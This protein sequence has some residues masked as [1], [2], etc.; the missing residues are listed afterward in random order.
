[1][2]TLLLKR[3]SFNLICTQGE[4]WLDGQFSCFTLEPP[5]ESAPIKPR[6]IPLGIYAFAIA[7]P[8]EKHACYHPLLKEIPDFGA[9]EIYMG[10][11]PSDTK[12]RILV[13]K[14]AGTNAVYRSSEAFADLMS[15]ISAGTILIVE[16]ETSSEQ[17]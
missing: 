5:R 13:G 7:P 4:L 17:T 16:S 14:A 8:N 12:A 10:N 3:T 6:A 11:F 9:I 1:M 2:S 15:V